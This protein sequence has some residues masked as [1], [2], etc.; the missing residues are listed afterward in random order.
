MRE[1]VGK[2]RG[3]LNKAAILVMLGLGAALLISSAFSVSS[4]LAIFGLALI[5]WGV[6]LFYLMPSKQVPLTLLNAVAATNSANVE[7]MLKE[8]D[9]TQSGI[10]LPPKNLKELESS[11]IFLPKL[12]KTPLPIPEEINE[13]LYSQKNTGLLLTPPGFEFSKFFEQELGRS[14]TKI[15]VE[16]LQAL[17]SKLLVDYLELAE[18]VEINYQG[19][20]ITVQIT[21]SMLNGVCQETDHYRPRMHTQIGCVLT[22]ALACMLA[23]VTGKPITIKSETQNVATKLT[24]MEYEIIEE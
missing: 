16:Q 17:V 18:E 3:T 9:S 19:N 4:Y 1:T 20:L 10:Y 11:L 15:D 21:N 7:R 2:K 8:F 24:V 22:S 5:F 12:P 13:K 6:I 14:F 23:K